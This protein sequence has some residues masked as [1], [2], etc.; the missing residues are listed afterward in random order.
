MWAPSDAFRLQGS[1][2]YLDSKYDEFI[3]EGVNQANNRAVIH[4]PK[5]SFN[6]LV[7]GRLA[8]TSLGDL[9]ASLD[10]TWTDDFYTY[11]YQL[12]SSG[13]NYNPLRPIAGDTLV[14]SYGVLN[15]RLALSDIDF[16]GVQGEVTLWSRNLTDEDHIV[17]YIDFG[18]LFGNLTDAY[19]LEPRTYGLE[20]S[21]K[22]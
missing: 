12:A 22:W 10:Y 1:Y 3:D 21:I 11:P 8:R 20:L 9:R 4:A 2:G 17:N 16:G 19:Y 14:K 7:D 15:G 6:V 18:P 13:P 5:S